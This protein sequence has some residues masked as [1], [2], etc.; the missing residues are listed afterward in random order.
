MIRINANVRST[1]GYM[2]GNVQAEGGATDVTIAITPRGSSGI[3]VPREPPSLKDKSL[4]DSNDLGIEITADANDKMLLVC[5]WD[6][7]QRPSRHTVNQLKERMDELKE[8]GIKIFIVQASIVDKDE[9]QQHVEQYNIPFVSGMIGTDEEKTRFKWGVRSLP[10]LI[11]ADSE[12]TV[13]ADGF[14]INELDEKIKQRIIRNK[15]DLR[16]TFKILLILILKPF[17]NIDR[18]TQCRSGYRQLMNNI[19]ILHRKSLH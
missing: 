7:Q 16:I 4:P 19:V 17:S 3:Y 18:I 11:L 9:L 15:S 1:S 2:Y 13:V 8:Q 5:F 14:S 10:W 12:K 6:Y